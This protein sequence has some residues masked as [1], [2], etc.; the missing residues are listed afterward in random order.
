MPLDTRLIT[1]P[2]EGGVR[3]VAP[4]GICRATQ[5]TPPTTTCNC[6]I[7]G[8]TD[9]FGVV[10]F[11]P[12]T[13]LVH[14]L[15]AGTDISRHRR[16]RQR[17]AFHRD[18][19]MTLRPISHSL[20]MRCVQQCEQAA[21]RA[22]EWYQAQRAGALSPCRFFPS[23]SEYSHE[24]IDAHGLGRGLWLTLR[25][26]SRCRPFGPSGFDP[27]PEPHRIDASAQPKEPCHV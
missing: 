25:R 6:E 22:I 8:G 7:P 9:P 14:S 20:W 23:C 19:P 11:H 12:F 21:L 16:F 17:T 5:P 4:G 26:L 27:V 3:P 10:S 24:A 13:Q 2:S 1:T 15:D 18:E